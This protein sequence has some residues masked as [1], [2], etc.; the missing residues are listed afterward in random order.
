M[1]LLYLLDKNLQISKPSATTSIQTVKP[2]KYL[3]KYFSTQKKVKTI[4][5][6]INYNSGQDD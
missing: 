2:I 4:I 6:Y 5:F 3:C 1:N